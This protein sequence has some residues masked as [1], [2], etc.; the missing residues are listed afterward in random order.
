V[1]ATELAAL[2]IELVALPRVLFERFVFAVTFTFV[3]DEPHANANTVKTAMH[4]A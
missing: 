1:L 4:D 3:L 2:P